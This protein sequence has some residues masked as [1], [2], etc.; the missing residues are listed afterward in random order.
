MVSEPLPTGYQRFVGIEGGRVAGK[1]TPG[2]QDAKESRAAGCY[3]KVHSLPFRH[4]LT[5]PTFD[6][7]GAAWV[8]PL[9]NIFEYYHEAGLAGLLH[10]ASQHAALDN[11]SGAV[12]FDGKTQELV[13][14]S[15]DAAPLLRALGQK[16]L[17]NVTLTVQLMS[18]S[19]C[20][21]IAI[22]ASPLLNRTGW[23]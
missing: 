4:Y 23:R 19:T 11:A 22:E 15:L 17:P 9:P 6:E 18:N 3:Q 12:A 2:I 21:G 20:F 13:M 16:S 5:S 14:P 10:K 1:A 8:G 7:E